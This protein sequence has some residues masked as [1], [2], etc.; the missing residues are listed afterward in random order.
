MP[1][2]VV[3]GDTSQTGLDHPR[4]RVGPMQRFLV[5]VIT[6][7]RLGYGIPSPEPIPP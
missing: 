1:T 6:R 4:G 5:A 2:G 3:G 7:H